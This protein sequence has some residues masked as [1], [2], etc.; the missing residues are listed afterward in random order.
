MKEAQEPTP[1]TSTPNPGS[2]RDETL[3]RF[4]LWTAFGIGIIAAGKAIA[5]AALSNQREAQLERVLRAGVEA[6]RWGLP[7]GPPTSGP[8]VQGLWPD[9]T[10][11]SSRAELEAGWTK[12]DAFRDRQVTRQQDEWNRRQQ[13]DRY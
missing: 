6:R 11:P 12:D 3:G 4:I 1:E 7:P 9:N 5:N 2:T 8:T 10:K 13:E